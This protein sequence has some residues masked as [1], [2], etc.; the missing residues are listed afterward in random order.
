MDRYEVQVKFPEIG[1]E[2]QARLSSSRVALVGVGGLGSF[3]AQ[4][5]V[6][7]GVGFLRIIDFDRVDVS[8]LQR[9]VLYTESDVGVKKVEAAAHHLQQINSEVVI[10]SID[11]RLT[12]NNVSEY[13]DDVDLIMD[14]LDNYEARFIINDFAK[15]R[16]KD[17]IFGSVA[18]SYG[19]SRVFLSEDNVCLRDVVG[20]VDLSQAPTAATGGLITPILAVVTGFMVAEAFKLLV[21]KRASVERRLLLVDLWLN[22]WE[23]IAVSKRPFCPVCDGREY[24]SLRGLEH[25]D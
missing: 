16:G 4:Q 7:A 15:K 12:A 14:G 3:I 20:D 8:N 19:M 10:E 13:L 24:P 9:Q 5:M 6:R 17:Y 1:R 2:G 11:D 18:G 25:E 21:G 23:R 22:Q